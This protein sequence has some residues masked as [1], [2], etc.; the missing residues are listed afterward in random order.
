MILFALNVNN[1]NDSAQQSKLDSYCPHPYLRN[2][3]FGCPE[4]HP[5]S[6]NGLGLGIWTIAAGMWKKFV[7]MT[8]VSSVIF[9]RRIA[10]ASTDTYEENIW[11]ILMV[12]AI[13][14]LAMWYTFIVS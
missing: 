8:I 12:I 1:L 3:G 14:V 6:G 5:G 4:A 13:T 10:V 2:C 7:P 11:F 9:I